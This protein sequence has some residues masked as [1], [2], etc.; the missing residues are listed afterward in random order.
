MAR[1][2]VVIKENLTWK[3]IKRNFKVNERWESARSELKANKVWSDVKSGMDS[4]TYETRRVW[5]EVKA[6][7]ERRKNKATHEYLLGLG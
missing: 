2:N 1:K 4:Y 5:D 7:L 3:N 6:E